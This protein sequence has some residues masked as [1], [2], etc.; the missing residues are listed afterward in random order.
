LVKQRL[1]AI[2]ENLILFLGKLPQSATI[3]GGQPFYIGVNLD[4]SG[5]FVMQDYPLEEPFFSTLKVQAPN[6]TTQRAQ[7]YL[8]YYSPSDQRKF[9]IKTGDCQQNNIYICHRRLYENETPKCSDGYPNVFI[10]STFDFTLDPRFLNYRKLSLNNKRVELTNMMTRLDQTRSYYSFFNN[11]WY[12]SLPCF[13]VV[14]ITA[15]KD[16]ER[17][18]LKYCEWKGMPVSCAAIFTTFPTDRGMC[19]SFN[20]K[21]ADEIFQGT[22]YPMLV[23]TMQNY[24]KAN[25]YS[26][27]T[28]PTE[29]A[30]K[31]EPTT[32]PGR[33]KGLVVI[34][35]AHSDLFAPSSV[36]G[37]VDGFIGIIGPTNSF[38]FMSQEGFDIRPGQSNSVILS[39]LRIDA[40]GSL[41]ALNVNDRNCKFSDESADLKF[42]KEYSYTN[43]MFECSLLFAKNKLKID[44]NLADACIPWYF[45]SPEDSITICNPWDAVDFLQ[46]M[47]NKVK[48]HLYRR[49]SE[50]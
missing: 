25:S 40:D 2:I 43:C 13:D 10:N 29:F 39:A 3:L 8:A 49:V 20:M 4:L 44:K 41:R 17:A 26:N 48:L 9:I 23:K 33:N 16:G 14:G 30:E 46:L 5:T 34:L 11:L 31:L 7:C 32:I 21:A 6:K 19:C 28:L 38:P 27:S 15:Q 22:T 1:K 24:D 37:D 45:P 47:I 12:S 35:D 36:D 50:F 18:L 42:Y